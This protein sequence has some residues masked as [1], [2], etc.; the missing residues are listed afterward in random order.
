[1]R[2]VAQW[3][4]DSWTHH[5]KPHQTPFLRG[6]QQVDDTKLTILTAA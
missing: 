4:I 5:G 3:N 1:M 2:I 6:S